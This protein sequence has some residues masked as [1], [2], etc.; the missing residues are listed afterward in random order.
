LHIFVSDM[1]VGALEGWVDT[2]SIAGEF[3]YTVE[4]HVLEGDSVY[5]WF[6]IIYQDRQ[7]HPLLVGDFGPP[8]VVLHVI[9]WATVTPTRGLRLRRPLKT[10]V[11]SVFECHT[12]EGKVYRGNLIVLGNYTIATQGI[13]VLIIIATQGIK[14]LSHVCV[15]LFMNKLFLRPSV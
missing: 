3:P 2:T 13:K 8:G 12:F 15:R 5:R 1:I 4:C 10:G 11:A 14:V 7:V 9:D 6:Y